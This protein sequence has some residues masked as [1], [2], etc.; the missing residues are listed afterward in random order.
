MGQE[1]Q[2]RQQ[3]EKQLSEKQQKYNEKQ[4]QKEAELEKKE[5]AETKQREDKEKKEQEDFEKWKD[6]FAVAAEG[7]ETGSLAGEAAVERFVD[8]IKVRKVVLLEDLAADFH[9]RTSTAIDRLKGLERQGRISGIFDD[10]GK[11][12]YI[13]TE[14]MADVSD[15]LKNKGR[16]SR[17]DLVAACN[18][19]VRLRPTEEGKVRL[20][21]EACSVLA[22][23]EKVEK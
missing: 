19:M 10:R 14:E 22:A 6:M 16:I 12:I 4:K 15:W 21:E 5:A 20:K 11:F 9:M 23:F 7:E 18:K 1:R 13:T 8:Y 2:M 17:A 3:R